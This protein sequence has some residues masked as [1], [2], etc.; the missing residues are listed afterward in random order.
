MAKFR[1]E[2]VEESIQF[3]ATRFGIEKV[4]DQQKS[5]L[6]AFLQGRDVFCS[7][8]TGFGKSFTF[9]AYNICYDY[10]YLSS[11]NDS[12]SIATP[13]L[14]LVI[15]PITSLILEDQIRVFKRRE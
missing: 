2:D 14:S 4:K 5:A 11:R 9:Q 8:P 12:A 3:A 10:D 15:F 6:T 13:T 1:K 7:L